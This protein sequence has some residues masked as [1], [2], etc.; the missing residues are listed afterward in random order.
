[1]TAPGKPSHNG[2]LKVRHTV[3]GV[4]IRA[5]GAAAL[6]LSTAA[7]STL[8]GAPGMAH[9]TI[10]F[11]DNGQDALEWDLDADKVVIDSRPYQASVWRGMQVLG[12]VEPGRTILVM[13]PGNAAKTFRHRVAEVIE[14]WK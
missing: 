3:R 11:E 14:G 4:T 1:M 10:K 7:R 13:Q 5:T 12:A 8:Q 6:A 2:S 9:T